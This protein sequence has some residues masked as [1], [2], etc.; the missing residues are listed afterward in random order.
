MSG[1]HMRI[2]GIKMLYDEFFGEQGSIRRTIFLQ[3]HYEKEKLSYY[4]IIKM[5]YKKRFTD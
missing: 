4:S 3:T 1:N 2:P 5:L